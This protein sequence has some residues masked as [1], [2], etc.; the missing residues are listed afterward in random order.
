MRT[1]LTDD[2][3][4]TTIW[5]RKKIILYINVLRLSDNA[6]FCSFCSLFF[7]FFFPGLLQPRRWY[8]CVVST[9]AD[10]ERLCVWFVRFI[11][12][13]MHIP[14]KVSNITIDKK[15]NKQPTNRSIERMH[16]WTMEKQEQRNKL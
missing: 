3:R 2:R 8:S 15:R 12:K 5:R 9:V 11:E 13:T 6:S 7:G 4:I 16:K 1:N 10:I 14:I